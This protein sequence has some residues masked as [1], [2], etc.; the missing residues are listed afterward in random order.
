MATSTA[1]RV[2]LVAGASRGIGAETAKAFAAAGY[3][4]VLGARDADALAGVVDDIQAAGGT[5]VASTTDVGDIASMRALVDLALETYGGPDAA[6]NT[7]PGGPM[8]SRLADIDPDEFD[9][10]IRTNVRGNFLG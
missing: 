2:A 9:L 5:A 1:E 6:F 3:G 4:V 7:P 8:P 10:G